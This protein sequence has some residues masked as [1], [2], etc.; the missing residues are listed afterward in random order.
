ML[1]LFCALMLAPTGPTRFQYFYDLNLRYDGDLIWI[2]PQ[3]RL[4]GPDAI[5]NK[6]DHLLSLSEKNNHVFNHFNFVHW[7][8]TRPIMGFRFT[9]VV[10]NLAGNWLSYEVV[11]VL[12][13]RDAKYL[14]LYWGDNI[15]G[16]LH[17]KQYA[18]FDK[19]D[20]TSQ[21]NIVRF[22]NTLAMPEGSLAVVTPPEE[23]FVIQLYWVQLP[24]HTL[25]N[26]QPP[27]PVGANSLHRVNNTEPLTGVA[28]LQR[29]HKDLWN[30]VRR[31]RQ[32]S[33]IVTS[34]MGQMSHLHPLGAAYCTKQDN[35]DKLAFKSSVYHHHLADAMRTF[36]AWK[37]V[38]PGTV[39]ENMERLQTFL[40]LVPGYGEAQTRLI[41]GYEALNRHDIAL[42][43]K[44][45]FAPILQVSFNNAV[46]RRYEARKK[47]L[48]PRRDSFELSPAT[49]I[50]F[51]S[52]KN[53]G[54]ITNSNMLRF[55]IDDAP[56]APLRI[57]CAL[58]GKVFAELDEIPSEIRFS[59]AG[60][61]GKTPLTITAWFF[62]ETTCTA[63]IEVDVFHVDE[64]QELYNT[65]LRGVAKK[66]N[67][68]LT[69]LNHD[70]FRIRFKGKDLKPE[71]V[72]R[73]RKPL[74][75]AIVLDNSGSMQGEMMAAAQLAIGTF[76][77][78]LEAED[79]AEVLIFDRT[80]KRLH[81]FSN[82]AQSLRAAIHGT[83]PRGSTSLYDGLLVAHTDLLEQVGT[84][85]VIVISDGEDT[86]S[87]ALYKRVKKRLAD[88]DTMVYSIALG[89]NNNRLLS[90]S[91]ATASVYT[92]LDKL[93]TGQGEVSN[94]ETTMQGIYEEL[95]AF[96]TIEVNTTEKPK[97]KA[98]RVTLAQGGKVR[99][100]L[101]TRR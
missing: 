84:R 34:I 19:S 2:T 11:D 96:Y 46:T 95:K 27:A 47:E 94:L 60:F 72:E 23:E 93:I 65:V 12:A 21:E 79:L 41:E 40:A 90:I 71:K 70:D 56:T 24:V 91:Q 1:A 39:R 15:K 68:L 9:Y 49:H 73:N 54:T 31:T 26:K 55:D 14:H 28:R 97:R 6:W 57:E 52:P 51:R 77:N 36:V 53:G 58:G 69:Q 83:D 80:V 67:H 74:R 78:N 42:A 45:R 22:F 98:L 92:N 38:P 100:R 18:R 30:H 35:G 89:K 32:K 66:N 59:T 88:S 33:R 76:L 7:N 44:N 16:K 75:I 3:S 50:R 4:L 64:E 81:E 61:G 43:M 99:T 13:K 5:L 101:L 87:T 29:S 86:S 37:H 17:G 48:L 8:Q 10:E 25:I 85:V 20:M 82:D 62:N 63:T